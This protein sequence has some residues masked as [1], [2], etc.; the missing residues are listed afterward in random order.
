MSVAASKAQA[1]HRGRGK[2]ALLSAVILSCGLGSRGED[3]GPLLPHNGFRAKA[4]VLSMSREAWLRAF[5]LRYACCEA[6][7]VAWQE[8]LWPQ[9]ISNRCC[10]K[11]TAKKSALS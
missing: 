1:A 4:L 11:S 10:W 7:V 9:K 3:R 8:L 5:P 6:T 2:K